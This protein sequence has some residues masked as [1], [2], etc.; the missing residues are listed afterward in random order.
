MTLA[1]TALAQDGTSPI[2]LETRAAR[3]AKRTMIG[4]WIAVL[5]LLLRHREVI[6]SDTLSNYIHVWY[7]AERFWHGHGLPFRMPV[8][9]HGQAL[10]FSYGFIPWM[11]AVLL[12]PLMGEWSVTL[13]LGIGFVG[14]VLATFWAFPELRR[15]WWAV[16]VLINPALF[17]G[18]LFGQLPFLWAAA[19]LVLAIGFWRRDRRGLAIVFAALAQITHAPVLIPLTA[20][21]VFG[22]MRFAPD[23]R[24]LLR[25]WVLSLIPSLPAVYLVFASPVT[26]QTS[27]LWSAWVE[28]E[29]VSLRAL[30][31]IVAFG[32]LYLKHRDP[33]PKAAMAAATVMLEGQLVTMPISGLWV[34]V[35]A[36]NRRPD[37]TASSIPLTGTFVKGATYRVLTSD[38]GKW[39]QY[40]VV[41]AGARLDSE[42][43][44]ESMFRRSF[45]NQATYAKFLLNRQVDYVVIDNRYKRFRTNEGQLLAS[46]SAAAGDAGCIAGVRVEQTDATPA[47]HIYR[48]TRGC[49]PPAA[50]S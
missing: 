35:W 46:M 8:L 48:I 6:S 18:L 41:R 31:L 7:V 14:L 12:W 28:I 5:V 42:F 34:G 39:G 13:T 23:R 19:M 9:A 49:A 17:E 3:N 21:M 27:P 30:V 10:A 1:A 4:V 45:R 20:L 36:L 38:D 25:S 47:L 26:E 43:F 32:L 37:V 11:F 29:T 33:R 22:W 16:A 15:G 50:T 2:E 24:V 44:P 40:A